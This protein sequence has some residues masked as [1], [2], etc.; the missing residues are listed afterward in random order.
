MKWS[1]ALFTIYSIFNA[2]D[3]DDKSHWNLNNKPKQTTIISLKGL[4]LIVNALN[5]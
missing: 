4:K 3:V 5:N 1:N 2:I